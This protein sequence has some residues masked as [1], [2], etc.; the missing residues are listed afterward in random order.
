MYPSSAQTQMDNIQRDNGEQ[1]CLSLL[2]I[3]DVDHVIVMPKC[4]PIAAVFTHS[5]AAAAHRSHYISHSYKSIYIYRNIL[6][7]YCLKCLTW[8]IHSGVI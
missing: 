6:P 8:G 1:M 7:K 4:N 5:Y 3:M 2:G